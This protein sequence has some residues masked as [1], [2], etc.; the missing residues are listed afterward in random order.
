MKNT[1]NLSTIE[2]N[3]VREETKKAIRRGI[4]I[5]SDFC[6]LCG[7]NENIQIHHK[8][9]TNPLDVA[10]VCFSCH[11]KVFHGSEYLR[12]DLRITDNQYNWLMEESERTGIS[13]SE[14]VRNLI[15]KAKK[16]R[17]LTR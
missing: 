5:K 10:F 17:W 11:R 12:I 13:K 2:A 3:R 9:Y 1:S 16:L 14:L 6:E 15:D 7:S 4:L 8:D